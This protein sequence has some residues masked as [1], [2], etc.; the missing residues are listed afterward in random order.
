MKGGHSNNLSLEPRRACAPEEKDV[1]PH[2]VPPSMNWTVSPSPNFSFLFSRMPPAFSSLLEMLRTWGWFMHITFLSLQLNHWIPSLHLPPAQPRRLHL[3]PVFSYVSQSTPQKI[4]GCVIGT[5][6]LSE[7]SWHRKHCLFNGS[8]CQNSEPFKN[9]SYV[10]FVRFVHFSSPVRLS[11]STFWFCHFVCA[12]SKLL[13]TRQP[14][15]VSALNSCNPEYRLSRWESQSIVLQKEAP[16][17]HVNL[18]A[19]L[20][21]KNIFSPSALTPLLQNPVKQYDDM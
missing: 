11:A 19:C 3:I 1:D 16:H 10:V 13:W 7:E 12:A 20:F 18:D 15:W 21:F 4:S 2:V 14:L 9:L 17:N 5:Q 8:W 6:V